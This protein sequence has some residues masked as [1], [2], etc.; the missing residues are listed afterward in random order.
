M[1]ETT[2]QATVSV[3]FK[4]WENEEHDETSPIKSVNDGGVD[5]KLVKTCEYFLRRLDY[6][7]S[8]HANNGDINGYNLW[9]SNLHKLGYNPIT[10]TTIII[11]ETYVLNIKHHPET[12][13]S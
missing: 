10:P 7:L 11:N 13:V 2:N 3:L 5:G 1:V 6:S 9:D 4:W 8:H 12:V